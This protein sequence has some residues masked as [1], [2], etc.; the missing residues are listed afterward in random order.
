MTTNKDT[1][2]DSTRGSVN[3]AGETAEADHIGQQEP[4]PGASGLAEVASE[5]PDEVVR[6]QVPTPYA[7]GPVNVYVVRGRMTT[8]VDVGPPTDEGEAALMDG[9][10]DAGLSPDDI[11]QIVITHTHVDHHGGLARFL[12]RRG[13]IPISVHMS[14]QRE[15]RRERVQRLNF[16]ERLFAAC[17]MPAAMRGA[18]VSGLGQMLAL[19]PDVTVDRWLQDGDFVSMGDGTWRV[20]HTPGHAGSQICLYHEPTA[21]MVTGDHVLPHISSNAIIEPP[22]TNGHER[23]RTL[24]QYL[25]GMR[26]VAA[27][28]VALA[29]PGHGDPFIGVERL[30]AERIDMHERRLRSILDRLRHSPATVYELAV[31]MFT[32]RDGDQLVLA[33]SEVLGHLDLLEVR[34][35]V[36]TETRDGVTVYL[37][38]DGD[39]PGGSTAASM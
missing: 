2:T 5:L 16:Y 7:V 33:M 36:T 4:V 22:P 6:I 14:G 19:E 29:L 30:V 1:F 17:G 35:Q 18:V 12:R 28:P 3:G 34:E 37:A 8:L 10:A 21:T 26:R 25:D 9:L 23:P 27:L 24:V 31:T 38:V 32:P 13:P 11:D 39:A 15:F 20:L